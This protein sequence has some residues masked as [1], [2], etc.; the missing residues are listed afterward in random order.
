MSALLLLFVCLILADECD[1]DRALSNTMLSGGIVLSLLS[2]PLGNYW[3]G[4]SA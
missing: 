3:L 2:V 1:L 4:G